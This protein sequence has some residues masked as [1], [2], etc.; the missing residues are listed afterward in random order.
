MGALEAGTLQDGDDAF[1]QPAFGVAEGRV[2]R[3]LLEVHS[4]PELL[5]LGHERDDP[6]LAGLEEPLEHKQR[7]GLRVEGSRGS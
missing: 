5:P 3:H 4:A 2:K 7:E 6:A 1:L